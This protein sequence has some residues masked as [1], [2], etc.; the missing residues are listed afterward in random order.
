ME[1][2]LGVYLE[3]KGIVFRPLRVSVVWY[4]TGAIIILSR[5]TNPQGELL[6]AKNNDSPVLYQ[7]TDTQIGIK[8]IPLFSFLNS[9][10]K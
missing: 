10:V 4:N 6:Y 8:T 7:T 5:T 2:K 3:N 9:S 1:I